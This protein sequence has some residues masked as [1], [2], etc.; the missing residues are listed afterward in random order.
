VK[1]HIGLEEAFGVRGGAVVSDFDEDCGS[2]TDILTGWDNKSRLL[3]EFRVF[4]LG[5]AGDGFMKPLVSDW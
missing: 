1:H 4:P 3:D 2:E 5:M